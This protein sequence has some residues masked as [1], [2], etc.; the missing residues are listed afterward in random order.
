[1]QNGLFVDD[2]PARIGNGRRRERLFLPKYLKEAGADSRLEG[3]TRAEAHAILIKWADLESNGKLHKKKETSLEGEFLSEVFGKAL[4]YTRFSENLNTW[5]LEAKYALPDGEADAVIGH[6]SQTERAVRCII[7]FKGPRTDLDRHRSRG[8]TPVDQCW[9][10]MYAVP[11][12]CQWGIVCNY[13]SFRL[14][15]RNKTKHAYELFTLQ[16]LRDPQAF[17]EFYAVFSHGGLLPQLLGQKPRAEELLHRTETRQRTIGAELYDK[18]K[19]ERISLLRLLRKKPYDMSLDAAISSVQKLFDR[20]IFIAFCEDRLLLP[21]NALMRTWR[22]VETWSQATNPRWASFKRLFRSIDLGN[23]RANIT[24]YNGGLFK[25]DPLVDDLELD[26]ARTDFFKEIGTYEFRDEVNVDVLGHIFEK[27]VSDL[28]QIRAN[29]DALS[30]KPTKAPPGKR[31]REGIYYTPRNITRYIVDNTVGAVIRKS[32]AALAAK[33]RVDPIAEPT[34]KSLAAWIKYNEARLASLKRIRICDPACGSGAF[35]IEVYDALEN[36]YEEIIDA[37]C[38]QQGAGNE[39]LYHDISRHILRENL[40]GV[41][42]SGEAVEITQL[43][44]WLRTARR[45]ESLDDLSDH[46]KKGNSLVD[47]AS[48]DQRAFNWK[49]NFPSVIAE[50]GF[51]CIVGNPPYVKLQNFRQREPKIA[52]YLVKNYKSAQTGNFDLYLPFIERGI[53]LLKPGGCMGFIAPSVWVFNDYGRGLRELVCS[54]GAL[55]RFV[56]FK[57]HQVFEDATTYTA[58]QFFSS[59]KNAFVETADAGSGDLTQLQFH[60]VGYDRLDQDAWAMV[61]ERQ[62]GLLDRIRRSCVTL[63]EASEGIIVGIQTSADSI[64]HLVDLGRGR[65]WSE[66]LQDEVEIEDEMVKPLVSGED[67][68]PFATP[69]TNKRLIFPYHVT[70]DESRLLTEKEIRKFKRGWAY[71]KKNERALRGREHGKMD[72]ERWYGYVYPKNI[73]KQTMPKLLVPRLL[74]SLKASGDPR[75]T[76]FLDNV[77][78]GGVILKKAWDLFF[79]LGI[80]NSNA[81]NYVWRLTSKPFRGEYRSANKQFIAPLPIPKTKDQK[82]LTALAKKLADLHEKRLAS[83]A[84]VHRRLQVDLPPKELIATSP[85]PPNLTGR[86]LEFDSTPRAELF[87]DMEKLADR[88]LKPAERQRWDE[89]LTNQTQGMGLIKRNIEDSMAELNELV[90][91]LYGLGKEAIATIEQTMQKS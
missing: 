72:H 66:A 35:L 17:Q 5:N 87:R 59:E 68:V 79:V 49:E 43:A 10:Y 31:K 80:L 27:S 39:K 14:Y 6:F 84:G 24:R 65:Y 8:I 9:N 53:S 48:V 38:L 25:H 7:E 63:A 18:Y 15:H 23:E 33:F 44:L 37:L 57:S 2:A 88:P 77:D 83:A 91:G 16:G 73:D 45:G 41:D 42:L 30:E 22:D 67:A 28:E 86:M 85:L 81:C 3:T 78:V 26:D 51:D 55:Q 12:A 89:Y 64:Y 50:G 74:L 34:A 11:P 4:G 69:R 1:M 71:L 90:Y 54:T 82:P 29:P 76:R 60:H 47:D 52:E 20:I 21:E 13:V 19:E 40:Y 75:G 46:V 56:D 61:D 58:L 36:T 62:H 32:F 70:E